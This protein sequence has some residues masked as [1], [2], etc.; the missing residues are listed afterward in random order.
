M[1]FHSIIHATTCLADHCSWSLG[2]MHKKLSPLVYT[3]MSGLSQWRWHTTWNVLH[4]FKVLMEHVQFLHFIPKP[5]FARDPS[6]LAGGRFALRLNWLLL[7]FLARFQVLCQFVFS[8]LICW[9]R[10]AGDWAAFRKQAQHLCSAR[11]FGDKFCYFWPRFIF[12][13]AVM[14]ENTIYF[15]GFYNWILICNCGVF[16]NASPLKSP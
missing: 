10:C 1:S 3:R 11:Y 16:L 14:N 2:E 7:F 9:N 12:F 5:T 13:S 4:K 8:R 6:D 15:L